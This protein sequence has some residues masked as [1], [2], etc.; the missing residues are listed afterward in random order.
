MRKIALLTIAAVSLA[1]QEVSQSGL[2]L[3]AVRPMVAQPERAPQ[4]MAAT[5]NEY[6]T[7]AALDVMR[8]GG[9]AVDAAVAIAFV[10][11]VVHPEAGNLGGSG[12]L[13]ARM[14]DGRTAVFDYGGQSPL[15]IR[16]GIFTKPREQNVGYRSIAVPGTPAGMGLAHAKFGK[17]KWA[18]CLEPARKLAAEGHPAS[19]R[20]ELIL[21]L[22]VPVMKPYAD[23]AKIFL[24]GSD[25]P[26]KQGERVIQKDLADTIRRL[27][28]KGWQEF[29]TGETASRIVADMK[30]N[31]GLIT[32]EDLSRYRAVESKP[33]EITYRGYPVLITPPSSSGGTALAAMLNTL[34]RF[35]LKLGMEGSG[36]ARHLQIEAM[37]VGFQARS[38]LLAGQPVETLITP[39]YAAA[40]SRS[41]SLERAAVRENSAAPSL[42]SPET[43]HFT[44]A[45][46]EGNIVT[47]TYTLSGFFGSQVIV[48][49][50]G[51]LFN[52]HMSAFQG[53]NLQPDKR[54]SSTM[55]PVILLRKDGSPWAAFGTP[56]GAT[57]P[58]TL[59]QIVTNLVDFQMS[60]RDAVEFPRVHAGGP[61]VD[62]EPAAL[63]F[64]VAEKL[65]SM[66]HQLNPNLR[67]QGD[68][69]AIVIE[70]K[71]GWKQGWADGR[72]GGVVRGY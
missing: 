2:R 70:E 11:A 43:T 38:Q 17:L 29:Y 25:Q 28:K 41:I 31:D 69:N 39:E 54:Y 19:Q 14:K 44:V 62:A 24:H 1:A 21:K 67:S 52:N 10:L 9:N 34:N 51:V 12:Y 42:E 18:E 71:T 55:S 60:L 59:V 6:A 3:E 68:V 37:R 7:Q 57:I 16:P 56:G 50:T 49:G 45:D 58:S 65:R 63:V 22:Q 26:L 32:A 35:D 33:I 47:N 15:A 27:Q 72:R 36:A 23:S 46:P 30:A 13:M 4:A 66:G 5:V 8:K 64:D 53:R 40:A 20:L 61:G 48:K